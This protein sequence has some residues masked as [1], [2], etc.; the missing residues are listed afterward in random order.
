MTC[1]L[2]HDLLDRFDMWLTP[3]LTDCFLFVYDRLTGRK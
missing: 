1:P 2:L 3:I